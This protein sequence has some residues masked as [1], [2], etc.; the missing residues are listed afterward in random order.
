ML[1]AVVCLMFL[2]ERNRDLAML[3]KESY[4]FN[5]LFRASA[6]HFVGSKYNGQ[7]IERQ[8]FI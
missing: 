2:R 5:N 3:Y 8:T 7:I 1:Y 4:N 6:R